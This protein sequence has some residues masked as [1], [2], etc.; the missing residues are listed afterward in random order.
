MSPSWRVVLLDTKPSNPNHYLVLGVLDALRADPRVE[1]AERVHYGNAIDTARRIGANLLIAF[2]GEELVPAVCSRL[3]SL[4][5]HAA[6]WVTEDPYEVSANV[7][8]ADGFD[9]VFTN[10]SGSVAA[11]GAKGRHLPLAG[12]PLL[13]RLDV[14]EDADLRYDLFFAGTPWPNRVPLL[15]RV[16]TAFPGARI[17]VALASNPFLPEPDLPV[18]RSA[19]AWRTN[20]ADFVRFCNASR[21]V[22]GLHRTF[23]SSGNAP[24]ARTPGPRVFEAALAGTAQVVDLGLPEVLDCFDEGTEIA[25]FRSEDECVARI[26]ALLADPGLRAT[27]AQGAQD[28]AL[29]EHTYSHRVARL[30]DEMT[31]IAPAARRPPLLAA[32]HASPSR[33]LILHV[34]HNVAGVPPF[35]GVEIYQDAIARHL[36]DR[37]EHLFFVPSRKAAPGRRYE[38]QDVSRRVVE[39]LEFP[40]DL[41]PQT[42]SEPR[43]EEA[44]AK[45]LDRTG[46]SVVHFQ[47]LLGHPLSLPMVARALGVRSVL[48]LHDYYTVCEKFTLVGHRGDYCDAPTRSLEY[49]D[50]CLRESHGFL[51]GSQARRRA[52]MR[53][54]L[55]SVDVVHASTRGTAGIAESVFPGLFEDRPPFLSP[56]ATPATPDAL[57]EPQAPEAASGAGGRPRRLKVAILGNFTA[58]KGAET[59]LGALELLRDEPMDFTVFGRVDEPF[60]SRLARASLRNLEI[61]GPY[62]AGMASS[63]I[64]GFDVSVHASIWPETFCL[65]LSEAWQAG[66]VPVVSDIGALGE[67][68]ADGVDGL[69][70]RRDDNGELVRA[71]RALADSPDLLARL[72]TGAAASPRRGFA[73]HLADMGELYASLAKAAIARKPAD[74][75]REK[76]LSAWACG[77]TLANPR[78]AGED[79]RPHFVALPAPVAMGGA[80]EKALRFYRLHGFRR[81]AARIGHEIRRLR[82]GRAR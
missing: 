15:R 77:V 13:H 49:C 21:V 16:L 64:R 59:I 33:P 35:G 29:R 43:R 9:L 65:A 76:G 18:A 19:Y 80:L 28:R 75:A 36:D 50:V 71:L 23:S 61:A 34:T 6:L 44:F 37:F 68:V 1:A 57:P 55:E 78:W 58:Q 11:Y 46:T 67:R 69:K 51:P 70:I 41:P 7:A 54:V 22:L 31:A 25:G 14:R 53:A 10:D 40:D 48:T 63:L 74:A 32:G 2:D 4:C 60:G 30:L 26:G 66:L 81:T 20:N 73:E 42:A 5:G 8:N 27:L 12:S 39:T 52:F 38:L 72:R 45:L 82:A 3:A 56:V 24:S 62:E 17:K 47:H 79:A